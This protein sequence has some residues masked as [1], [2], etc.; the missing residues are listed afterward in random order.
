MLKYLLSSHTVDYITH[1]ARSFL[2]THSI[3]EMV[4][5]VIKILVY[6]VSDALVR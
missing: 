4:F 3:L 5:V 6:Y 1:I 2:L